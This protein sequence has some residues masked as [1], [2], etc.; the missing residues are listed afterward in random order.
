VD[1]AKEALTALWG[2]LDAVHR[3]RNSAAMAV[4]A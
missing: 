3:G 2:A 1:T 4:T